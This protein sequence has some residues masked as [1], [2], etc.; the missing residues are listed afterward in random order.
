MSTQHFCRT[1]GTRIPVEGELKGICPAC[2]LQRNVAVTAAVPAPPVAIDVT[3]VQQLFPQFEIL[4]PIGRGGMGAVYRARQPHLDRQVALKVLDPALAE[5]PAFAERFAKE[6]RALARLNHR[7][8]VSLHDFG[9]HDGNYFLVME[10][11]EGQNLRELIRSKVL[12]PEQ[13]LEIVSQICAGLRYAHSEG[14]VHRDI[15]PENI[16]V[17]RH[18][19]VKIADFGLA[20]LSDERGAPVGALTRASQVMGTPHYMAPEQ[21]RGPLGVDHRADIYSLGVVL[22]ELLTSELP[23]GR[24]ERPSERVQVDVRLD[25]VV[26]R[27]M[28]REPE[29]RYQ[30]VGQMQSDVDQVAQRPEA[31]APSVP[32]QVAGAVSVTT[33]PTQDWWMRGKVTPKRWGAAALGV[34][35]VWIAVV[36]SMARSQEHVWVAVAYPLAFFALQAA[37]AGRSGRGLSPGRLGAFAHAT[38][39]VALFLLVS[40]AAN[41]PL[42]RVLVTALALLVLLAFHEALDRFV[43]RGG[44]HYFATGTVLVGLSVVIYASLHANA[45]QVAYY[46]GFGLTALLALSSCVAILPSLAFDPVPREVPPALLRAAVICVPA[47]VFYF[48]RYIF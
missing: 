41:P 2:L 36:A 20:K 31:R 16:L 12:Q 7:H 46:Y 19:Q 25:E 17:D 48:H 39:L 13:A 42:V 30:Q 45:G 6:A 24:F 15:K 29:R 11:V 37:R 40:E 1:C 26:M 34:A 38:G 23:L 18:G 32:R 44:L 43:R 10:Y 47:A 35:W 33:D 28:E 27:A 21:M 3:S 8:I 22:Y 4:A 14:V 9:H 5:D